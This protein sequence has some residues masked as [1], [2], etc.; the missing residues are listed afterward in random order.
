MAGEDSVAAEAT[1]GEGV[2]VETGERLELTAEERERIRRAVHE[3]EQHT[4]AE[5][6]PMIVSRSGLYRDAQHRSGLLLALVV[7]TLMLTTE[8]FWLPWGWHGSNAVWLVLATILAY[9]VGVWLGTLGPCIRFL[10]PTDRLQH[11]VRLRAERAFTKHAVS[12][13]RERTGVLILVSLLEHQ[14]YVLA[15]QSIAQRVPSEGW[16]SVVEAAVSR[17]TRGDLVGGLCQGIQVCGTVL[18]EMSPSRSGD[19]PDELSNELVIE[20]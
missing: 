14:I 13:T 16:S 20:S 19:N 4:N 1:L 6:V 8:L 7:L 2:P 11:K 9:G 17:L 5:I 18:A 15:D 12:Q 3:A 10:T